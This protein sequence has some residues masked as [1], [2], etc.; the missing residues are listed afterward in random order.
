MVPVGRSPGRYFL[1]F[2]HPDFV[3]TGTVLFRT[4]TYIDRNAKSSPLQQGG[5]VVF[6]E[7][8]C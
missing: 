6:Y 8:S 1:P 5:C 2:V 4:D 3:T 7:P